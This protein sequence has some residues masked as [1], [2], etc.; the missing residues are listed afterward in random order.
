MVESGK[1]ETLYSITA[2]GK[3]WVQWL[4]LITSDK[5]EEKNLIILISMSKV[6]RNISP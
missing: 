6:F 5:I 1:T 4:S 2:T 3:S